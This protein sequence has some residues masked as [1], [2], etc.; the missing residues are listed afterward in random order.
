M[1]LVYT[2]SALFGSAQLAS[3]TESILFGRLLPRLLKHASDPQPTETLELT[4][5]L[6]LDYVNCFIFGYSSGPNFLQQEGTVH[7]FLEHYEQR[8]CKESFWPQEL[9]R[10]TRFLKTVGINMVPKTNVQSTKY[11]EQW[12]M[13]LCDNADV[14]SSLADRGELKDAGDIPIVYQQVKRAVDMN[15]KELDP[16]AKRLEVASELF[17]HMCR[18]LILSTALLQETDPKPPSSWSTRSSRY[19]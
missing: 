17:D 11:L 19:V 10:T 5:S 8:Y 14:A 4:Y 13:R 15:S 7:P 12:M 9:P 16:H 18:Y 1:S 3:I 6:C 2:K